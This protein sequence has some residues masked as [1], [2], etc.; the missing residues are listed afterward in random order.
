MVDKKYIFA[1]LGW[2]ELLK[3]KKFYNVFNFSRV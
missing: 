1:E 2:K 3:D